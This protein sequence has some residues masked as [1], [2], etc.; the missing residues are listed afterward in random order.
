MKNIAYSLPKSA[1]LDFGAGELTPEARHARAYQ[2]NLSDRP[3]NCGLKQ[4]E[5]LERQTAGLMGKIRS[6]KSV[7]AASSGGAASAPEITRR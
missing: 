2:G 5:S 6:I 7:H 1:D 3:V 4:A